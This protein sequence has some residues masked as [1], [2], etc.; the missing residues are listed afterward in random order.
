[1]KFARIIGLLLLLVAGLH[2]FA[3]AP[4]GYYLVWSDEFNGSSLDTTKW[5]YWLLGSRRDAVNVTNAV[6]LNGSNLIITTYTSNSVNYTAMVATDQHFRTKFGY[7]EA[8][9]QW[10]DT[11]GMWS[12]DWMQS[13]TMGA[14]INDPVTSGSE[15]DISEHRSTDGGSNGD[16]INQVQNNLHWNGYGSYAKS[17]GSGNI[18]TSGGTLGSG[19]HTYGF[20]WTP[21]V[22]NIFIDGS[23]LRSWNYANNG[24]PISASTE[25]M[26]F[27]SEVDDT[28][29]TWAGTIPAGGYGSLAASTTKL[30]VDYAR[31]YAPT[32]SIFWTGATSAYWTN[33][34]NWIAGK[35]PWTNA[36]L[37]FGYL[38]T[39]NYATALGVNLSVDSLTMLETTSAISINDTN[40][41]TLGAGGLDL[42]SASA[43]PQINCPLNLGAAQTWTI[44]GTIQLYVNSNLSGTVALTKS[45]TGTVLL[46]SSNSFSGTLYLDTARSSSQTNSDGEICVFTSGALAN[47]PSPL[48]MRN[49]AYN[50]STFQIN[51]TAG[52][53]VVA[54]DFSISGR[55]STVPA[56]ENVAGSNTLAGGVF[57]YTGGA[58]LYLTSDAGTLVLANTNRYTGNIYSSR[59]INYGGAG[60]TLITGRILESSTP[61]PTSI[62]KTGTGALTLAATNTYGGGT[63]LTNGDLQAVSGGLGTGL[64]TITPD[65]SWAHLHAADGANLTNNLFISGTNATGG[66]FLMGDLNNSNSVSTFSGA[67]TVA[68]ANVVASGHVVGPTGTGVL[69]L[70]G[71]VD[72]TGTAQYFIVRQGNVRFSGGGSYPQIQPRANTTSLGA[73]NGICPTASMEIGGNGSP[74]T[75]TVFDLNGCNQT[76]GGLVTG[77]VTGNTNNLAWVTNSAPAPST[78]TLNL[79]APFTYGGSIVGNIGITLAGGNQ[80]FTKIGTPAANGLYSYTGSTLVNGGTLAL[81]NV[82]LTGTPQITIAAGAVV[83]ASTGG[84]NLGASQTL[85]GQGVLLGALTVNGTLAP[86]TTGIGTLSVTGA[87]T[88]A[89]GGKYLC[90]LSST[91]NSPGTNNDW[92]TVS[93][94]LTVSATS[95]S[96]FVIKPAAPGLAGWNNQ[97]NYAWT[98]LTAAGGFSGFA[99]NKFSVDTSAFTNNLG[100]GGLSVALSGD[101]LQLVFTP[102][103]VP[104]QITK[105]T[106]LANGTFTLSAQVVPGNPYKLL[107]ATNLNAPV[108]WV[109][110]ATNYADGNGFLNCTDFFATNYLLRF[111]RIATP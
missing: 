101:N 15:I 56:I 29:T 27:S 69:N 78:L 33:A 42:I 106:I 74:T 63:G 90:G 91:T 68:S 80:T 10:G 12:A 111:Y 92:L 108:F 19:F 94:A 21:T 47:V 100:G 86:G 97:T 89:A 38:T 40:A 36:D 31:Y 58:G 109:P 65:P 70:T 18:P 67:I 105:S 75:P 104:L 7:W 103:I 37:T 72:F 99:T 45:G 54:Q 98:L 48:Q 83:D 22:Y 61:A 57:F 8:S 13:P 34:A 46:K 64:V 66:G 59:T 73:N 50:S 87:V 85:A 110:L 88:L 93:G 23:N 9:I 62:V 35:T 32:T 44:G 102:K 51:G 49:A 17:A 6:S 77:V 81:K 30:S 107:A 79:A 3:A 25:W 52:S 84:L 43:N 96:P 5:D 95:G 20:Q 16:I 2:V 55:A 60:N 53:V 76:L 14:N 28:S 39:N 24:V 26:I 71:P 11:N 4:A 1:M 41:L 82:S